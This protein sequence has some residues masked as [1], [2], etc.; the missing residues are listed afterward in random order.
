MGLGN[1][2]PAIFYTPANHPICGDAEKGFVQFRVGVRGSGRFRVLRAPAYPTS[3][4]TPTLLSTPQRE[5]GPG[6]SVALRREVT[7]LCEFC[8]PELIPYE[9]IITKIINCCNYKFYFIFRVNYIVSCSIIIV[10]L[11]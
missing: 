6:G 2:R 1:R 4:S 3:Q 10:L 8:A 11:L 7:G 9:Y 5:K